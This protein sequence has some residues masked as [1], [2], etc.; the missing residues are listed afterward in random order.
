MSTEAINKKLFSVDEY[1]R[2]AEM[3][4]LPETRRFELVRGEIIEMT[5][6]GSPHSG[7]VNR[8]T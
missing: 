4:I 8:L 5:I 7:R 6:P 3:G 1:H 2:M